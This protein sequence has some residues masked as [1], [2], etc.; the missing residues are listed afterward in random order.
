MIALYI[1]FGL[2][3]FFVALSFVKLRFEAQYNE[4]LTL[5]LRVLFLTF[6]LLPKKEKKNEQI[7][8]KKL[9]RKYGK[10]TV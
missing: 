10:K 8:S 4:K 3:A 2:L 6:T 7:M 5:K 1:F 9:Q